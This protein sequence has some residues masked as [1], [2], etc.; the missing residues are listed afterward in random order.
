MVIVLRGWLEWVRVLII[1]NGGVSKGFQ[2]VLSELGVGFGI[3]DRSVV[4]IY[5]MPP[6]ITTRYDIIIYVV[7][8]IVWKPVRNITTA[9][10]EK[11]FKPNT[12]G[13]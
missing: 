4:D 6:R 9:D 2:K 7:G 8:D 1:G 13:F 12:F 5:E 11:V 3:V 10:I